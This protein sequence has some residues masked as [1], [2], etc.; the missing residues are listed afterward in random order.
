MKQRSLSWKCNKKHVLL[1][2]KIRELDP[3]QDMTR[4]GITNRAIMAARN[5]SVDSWKEV[6][7]ELPAL[8]KSPGPEIAIPT[9]MQVKIAEELSDDLAIIEETIKRSLDLDVLQTQFEIQLL[10]KNY[11]KYLTTNAVNV[12]ESKTNVS[13]LTGPEMVQRLVHILL[14]NREVDRHIIEQIK[15]ILLEWEE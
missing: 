13:D 12:G 4:A 1:E 10:W 2:H 5:L 8:L 6:R 15:S 9:A 7:D 14:L 3:N 11:L